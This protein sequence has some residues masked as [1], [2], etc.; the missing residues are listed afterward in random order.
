M[1]VTLFALQRFAEAETAYFSSIRVRAQPWSTACSSPV[2][3]TTAWHGMP[4]SCWTRTLS[5]PQQISPQGA[6]VPTMSLASDWD[7]L[8]AQQV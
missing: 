1:G 8:A 7:E 3:K 4:Y 5:A 6:S 2:L